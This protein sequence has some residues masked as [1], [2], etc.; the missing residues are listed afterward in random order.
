[1]ARHDDGY[2]R[3]SDEELAWFLTQV[4]RFV[5]QHPEDV[6]VVRRKAGLDLELVIKVVKRSRPAFTADVCKQL[7]HKAAKRAQVLAPV[8]YVHGDPH[9]AAQE[10][11]DY[12]AQQLY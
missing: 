7:A 1:M 10:A 11:L 3:F 6:E 9:P 8:V 12:A 2:P 5:P 4:Q